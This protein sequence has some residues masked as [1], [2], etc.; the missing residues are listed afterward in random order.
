M[1]YFDRGNRSGG[2]RGGFG[3]KKSFGGRDGG[4]VFM[5]KATCATCGNECEVPFK[6]TGNRDV[7]CS[8][9]FKGKSDTNYS[10]PERSFGKPSFGDKPMFQAV[11]D[12][13]GNDCEVPF[14]PMGG[15]P[16][17]CKQ[18]FNKDGNPANRTSGGAGSSDNKAQ[19]EML[20]A[21]LDKILK[22]LGA[23]VVPA[24]APVLEKKVKKE[25]KIEVKAAKPAKKAGKKLGAK[26]K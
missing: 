14:R 17:Y 12:K 9:C 20:N 1:A 25:E 16:V 6:P 22:A 4:K 3:G 5:H 2:S 24:P 15:K 13:C 26:K 18:C 21:K 8:N 7:F 10:R 19:F 11:C 23:T